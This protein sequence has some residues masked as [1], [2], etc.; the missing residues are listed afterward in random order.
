MINSSIWWENLKK[1]LVGLRK[2]SLKS[3]EELVLA[4]LRYTNG[5]GTKK[6]KFT[7][8]IHPILWYL[9]GTTQRILMKICT[10]MKMMSKSSICNPKNK[11]DLI[12]FR[13]RRRKVIDNRLNKIYYSILIF[14]TNLLKKIS[15]ILKR[16]GKIKLGKIMV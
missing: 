12:K 2:Q 8:L 4:K 3:Q 14:Y 15:P 6:R 16:R 11:G 13:K 10:R 1:I 9:T 5:V 7:E